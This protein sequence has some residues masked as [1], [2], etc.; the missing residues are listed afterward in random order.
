MIERVNDLNGEMQLIKGFV[1]GTYPRKAVSFGYQEK[2]VK[3][4]PINFLKQ[5]GEKQKIEVAQIDSGKFR[6]NLEFVLLK[7]ERGQLLVSMSG[8]GFR[9]GKRWIEFKDDK[10]IV[11]LVVGKPV[12]VTYPYK[13]PDLPR[14]WITVIDIPKPDTAV[15][16]IGPKEPAS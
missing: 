13:I 1:L 12:E 5:D 16:A 8:T 6:Y 11:P 14:V 10:I 15:L 9:D 2:N 4:T 3:I 7:I